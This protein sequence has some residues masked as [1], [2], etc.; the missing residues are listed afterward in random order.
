MAV[1]A[2]VG[3][4]EAATIAGACVALAN[5][6]LAAWESALVDNS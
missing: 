2:T 4:E 6:L 5:E 3:L 1:R